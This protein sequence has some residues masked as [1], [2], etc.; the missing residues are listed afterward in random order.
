MDDGCDYDP[1]SAEV[2]ADPAPYLRHLR[3]RCPLH[4]T[5]FGERG[6]YTVSR[7]A[8]VTEVLRQAELWSTR[9]GPGP[10]HQARRG[11]GMLLNADPP[12]HATQ[13]RI[14]NVAFT[15]RMVAEREP[16]ITAIAAE[17]IDGFAHLGRADLVEAFAYPLPVIVIAEVLGVRPEH[18]ATF[19]RWSDDIVAG[20]GAQP[21]K[22]EGAVRAF[23]EF[24]EY[25]AA[26]I[27]DRQEAVA[28][29]DALPDDLVSGL[30]TASYE[31]RTFTLTEMLGVL[32]QLLV[33]GNETTTSLITNLVFRLLEHPDQLAR[34]REHPELAEQAVEESLRYDA[35][36]QGLF[37]TNT[38][39]TTLCGVDLQPDTK[40]RVMFSSANRD[41]TVWERPDAFDIG[42]DLTTL[43]RHYGF[44]FG[45]HYCLGAPLARLEG[46]IAVRLLLDRL[47]GLRLDGEPV[48]VEPFLFRG[49]THFPVAWET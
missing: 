21:G 26:R 25:F 24:G 10:E 34:L 32:V 46:R 15:P 4:R 41:A 42:R 49:F 7:H 14:V 28:R 9:W 44:G 11:D 8:D 43:K 18:R 47:P 20:L 31:G 27:A 12:L 16:R 22:A 5:E 38:A 33:A 13:R 48:L 35:P 3:E 29:G 17:L 45:V 6:F 1:F 30:V 36:V 40:V 37:R 19:K 23:A 39:P 2:R